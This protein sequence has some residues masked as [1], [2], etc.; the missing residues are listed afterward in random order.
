[1]TNGTSENRG[2][3]IGV[4]ISNSVFKAVCLD[5]K[6]ALL[7]SHKVLFDSSQVNLPQ[8]LDFIKQLQKQFGSFDRIGIAVPG[9][10]RQDTKRIAFSTYIPEHSEIDLLGEVEAATGLKMVIENDANAAA[11]GEFQ[12]GAG[13]TGSNMFYATIGRGVGGAFI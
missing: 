10:V 2:K 5:A 1:M 9:L 6:G 3:L 11:F 13:R 7:G 4:E 12:L 8:L